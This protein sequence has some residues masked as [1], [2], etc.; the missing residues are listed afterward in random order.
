M[1]FLSVGV[2]GAKASEAKVVAVS[3]LQSQRKHYNIADIILY[4]LLDF[5][6]ELWGLPP[7]E[8]R[9]SLH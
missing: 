9:N 4:S 2:K 5:D 1:V 3:S 7:F 6:P 8:D